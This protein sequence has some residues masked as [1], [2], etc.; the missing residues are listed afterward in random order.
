MDKKKLRND[1]ILIA[2]LLVIALV[3]LITILTTRQKN[4]LT[5]KVYVQNQVVLTIDL[6]KSNGQDF[7]VEGT[8]GTVKIHV[9][10]GAIA[11]VESNCPHQ[12]CVHMGFVSDSAH[13]IICAY[14]QITIEI[15]GNQIND[16][17]V[18]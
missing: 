7:Y 17:E 1:L 11:V 5:A 12:D 2:S 4:N 13:P 9:C 14:N 18:N 10:D 16:V 3:S 15:S 6:D 8:N